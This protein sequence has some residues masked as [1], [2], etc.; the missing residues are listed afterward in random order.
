[1]VKPGFLQ[2][3]DVVEWLGGIEPMWS[4]LEF[5]SYCRLQRRPDKGDPAIQLATD[6]TEAEAQSSSLVF[7]LLALLRMAGEKGGAKLTTGGGLTR[8]VITPIAEIC[9]GPGYDLALIRSVT[10]VLNEADVWPAELLRHVVLEMRLVRRVGRSLTLTAKGRATLEAGGSGGLMADLFGTVF[11]RVNLGHWDGYPVPTWPQ[12]YIGIIVWS[13]AHA[14]STWETPERL[15]RYSTIPVIGV[16]EAKDDFA[17]HAFELRILRIL[18]IFGLLDAR[19]D[20]N[21]SNRFV[22]ARH[23]R[24]TQLYD[25]FFSFDVTLEPTDGGARH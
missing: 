12:S 24:K 4:H 7:A 5:E 13:L 16:L 15:A 18:S 10:K 19:K 23:Y 25:R 14:A 9:D 6:L 17:G 8:E 2:S 21:S 20:G 1:M 3:D 22:S 11:W